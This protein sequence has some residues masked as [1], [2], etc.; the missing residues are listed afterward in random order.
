M[1][2]LALK[3]LT[4]SATKSGAKYPQVR[5]TSSALSLTSQVPAG[6]NIATGA[7]LADYSD[8]AFIAPAAYLASVLGQSSAASRGF[9]ASAS[10]GKSYFG[11]SCVQCSAAFELTPH[12]IAMVIA[13]QMATPVSLWQ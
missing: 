13:A 10:A 5:L 1:L 8:R 4:T 12:S 9:A 2:D 11:D 7:P 3:S 6:I